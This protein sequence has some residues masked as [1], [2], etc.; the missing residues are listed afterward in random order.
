MIVEGSQLAIQNVQQMARDGFTIDLTPD[1]GDQ[2][3]DIAQALQAEGFAID[4]RHVRIGEQIKRL[5]SYN[6]P[7]QLDADLKTEVKLWVVSDRPM[8][9]D[10]AV[11]EAEGR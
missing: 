2:S 8:D 7:I 9:L 4:D 1:V 5:D 10:E 3:V 11:E 6:I